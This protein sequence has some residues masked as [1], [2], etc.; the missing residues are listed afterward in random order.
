M[1]ETR[2]S[3]ERFPSMNKEEKWWK[4][5]LK[6]AVGAGLAIVGLNLFL[7]STEGLFSK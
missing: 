7:G 1:S 2:L 4:K 6:I 3:A 5:F